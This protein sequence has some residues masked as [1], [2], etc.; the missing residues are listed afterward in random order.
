[1]DMLEKKKGRK[2][3]GKGW[4][5][6]SRSRVWCRRVIDMD[7]APH[8]KSCHPGP[9]SVLPSSNKR[10]DDERGPSIP[11]DRGGCALGFSWKD[12]SWDS[13]SFFDEAG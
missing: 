7:P 12:G 3:G 9:S 6:G 2:C 13:M 1:M 10:V 8:R 11:R 5:A 4:C